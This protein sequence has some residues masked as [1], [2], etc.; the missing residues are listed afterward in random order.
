MVDTWSHGIKI[1][2]IQNIETRSIH[3]RG[4][5]LFCERVSKGSLYMRF[6]I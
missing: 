6:E 5:N 3:A 1:N 4:S 2:Q